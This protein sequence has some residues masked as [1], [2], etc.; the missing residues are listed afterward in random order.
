[1]YSKACLHAYGSSSVIRACVVS[2]SCMCGAC[3]D[4]LAQ[5]KQTGVDGD[6]AGI[7]LKY[8]HFLRMYTQYVS[9]YD[10]CLQCLQRLND[11][12]KFQAFL[13]R[14]R[15]FPTRVRSEGTTHCALASQKAR[16]DNPAF[17]G[18]GL[19]SYLIMPVQ[20]VPRYE[21]LLKEILRSTADEAED[22][23]RYAA[24][25]SYLAYAVP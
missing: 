2:H 10:K 14:L 8:A 22:A 9:S 16:Q 13:V 6:I 11:N 25:P 5:L 7:F 18:L 3:S 4:L 1:M 17:G 12:K 24:G 21:M 20:R 19:T 15:D 23:P